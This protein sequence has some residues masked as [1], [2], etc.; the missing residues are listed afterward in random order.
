MPARSAA[1]FAT[2]SHGCS[3]KCGQSDPRPDVHRP[4]LPPAGCRSKADRARR[5]RPARDRH[6]QRWKSGA[7]KLRW[8][9][10]H[11]GRWWN[12]AAVGRRCLPASAPSAGDRKPEYHS[13]GCRERA[14][15]QCDT[16]RTDSAG[17]VPDGLAA[18]GTAAAV[19]DEPQR[20]G[21]DGAGCGCRR[22]EFSGGVER[23]A[24]QR[25]D[26]A[27]RRAGPV[28]TA[29]PDRRPDVPDAG[30]P[31]G[32]GRKL[33][34]DA[35]SPANCAGGVRRPI[36]GTAAARQHGY[37][38]PPVCCVP[39]GECSNPEPA[40]G[41]RSAANC[42]HSEAGDPIELRRHPDHHSHAVPACIAEA[43][44]A[45]EAD[46][47]DPAVPAPA[48]STYSARGG[49][50]DEVRSDR[51]FES[52]ATNSAERAALGAN[53]YSSGAT[54][55]R[56]RRAKPVVVG[57]DWE[58]PVRRHAGSACKTGWRGDFHAATAATEQCHLISF[59]CHG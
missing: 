24:A 45:R 59:E 47:Y 1:T 22:R 39:A 26:P 27:A 37:A 6:Q 31:A 11:P 3:P 29:R 58:F 52:A 16:A 15:E 42:V 10:G 7:D 48:A 9:P 50:A 44:P 33:R 4:I 43:D 20:C 34:P 25:P 56:P 41:R 8:C 19:G 28:R 23:H 12:P 2:A 30:R 18:S 35:E 38:D 46:G 17:S 49:V 14:G 13:P 57:G 54:D 55:C 53:D 36:A 21:T 51:R 40:G 5:G 32:P